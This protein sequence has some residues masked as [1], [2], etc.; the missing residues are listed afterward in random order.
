LLKTFKADLHLHTCLSPCGELE[1]SPRNVVEKSREIGLDIIAVCDHNS[2][3]N[4]EATIRVGEKCGLCVIPGMEICSKE[5]VHIVTLFETTEQSGIM[6]ELV[7]DHL[8]GVNQPKV[9]GNQV[10]ANENNEVLG[11]NPHLL[12]GATQLGLYEI[13]DK[14]RSLGGISIASHVDRPAYGIVSQ[15]GFVPP[16]LM[17]DAVEVTHRIPLREARKLVPEIADLPCVTA[18]DAHHPGDIGKIWTRFILAAPTLNEIRLAL[19][20]QNGRKV[21]I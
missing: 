9:F 14:V 10:V 16:D 7:Y 6:Q 19:N 13:V 15:L 20:G 5:E 1:M 21:E 4:T 8:S 2:A 17:I 3:E 12:I 11:E 18:S